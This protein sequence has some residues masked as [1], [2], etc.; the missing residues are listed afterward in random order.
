M[1]MSQNQR[2]STFL[3]TLFESEVPADQQA[4]VLAG[5]NS[6]NPSTNSNCDCSNGKCING[7]GGACNYVNTMD[8]TNYGQCG[9]NKNT[10]YTYPNFNQ[11]VETCGGG[12]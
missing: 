8:C 5:E 1:P 3:S 4:I 2:L 10:C 6:I 7:G 9:A 11:K 12:L